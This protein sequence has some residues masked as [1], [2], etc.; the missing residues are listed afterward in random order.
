M[1]LVQSRA[2][3]SPGSRRGWKALTR[4]WHEVPRVGASAVPGGR[5]IRGSLRL[6]PEGAPLPRLWLGGPTDTFG[7]EFANLV[8]KKGW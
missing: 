7:T 6:L 8:F 3:A 5:V 4:A 1:R 2:M